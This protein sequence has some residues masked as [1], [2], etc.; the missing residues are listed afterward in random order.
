[1]RAGSKLVGVGNRMGLRVMRERGGGEFGMYSVVEK[2]QM[3]L[4]G[5]R[6]G[7]KEKIEERKN[8]GEGED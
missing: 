5:R 4:G 2:V 6:L 8:R 3:R 7:C 1:M